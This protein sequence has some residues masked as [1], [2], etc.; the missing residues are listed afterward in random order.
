M[1]I[2]SVRDNKKIDERET[3]K[4][5]ENNKSKQKKTG[6]NKGGTKAIVKGESFVVHF[7]LGF[8]KLICKNSLIFKL[9]LELALS[10]PLK[11]RKLYES[12]HVAVGYR[13]LKI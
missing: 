5:K 6:Q 10:I 13:Y 8:P 2:I 4:P 12:K 3:Q 11:Q 1:P 9:N 7:K